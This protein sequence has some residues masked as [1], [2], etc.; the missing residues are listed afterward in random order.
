MFLPLFAVAAFG[1]EKQSV[2]ERE[3]REK[4][5]DRK[6]KTGIEKES[7]V[8]REK[9]R[10]LEKKYIERE[11]KRG[12]EKERQRAREKKREKERKRCTLKISGLGLQFW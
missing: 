11:T 7:E 12:K 6:R 2:C 5:I 8:D 9:V 3:E 4:E 10:V 1:R